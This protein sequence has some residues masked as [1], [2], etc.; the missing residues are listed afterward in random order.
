MAKNLDGESKNYFALAK[1]WWHVDKISPFK[2][3]E[4]N[5]SISGFNLHNFLFNP[6][7]NPRRYILEILNKLFG[8]YQDGLIKPI[9][10]SV[11]SFDDVIF[12][13]IF[14]TYF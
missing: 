6:F 3:Y 10:D 12:L 13:N 9:I 4:E 1:N 11:H 2:L 8:L 14:N 5:R 7:N